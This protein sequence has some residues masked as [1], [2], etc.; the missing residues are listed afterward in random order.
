AEKVQAILRD[1]DMEVAIQDEIS[2][3]VAEPMIAVGEISQGI[4][5]PMHKL[6]IITEKEL[7]KKTQ[8]RV[9]RNQNISNAER[10]KNYQELKI[11][12]YVVH[13]NHGIGK[14]I[15]V[16]TLKVNKLHKDY[17][18][19][20]YSGD[21][22]LYVP[23]DQIDLVQKYVGS[24]GKEPRLYKLGGTE[25]TKVKR[26]VQSSVEDIADELIKLYAER[27]AQK[28]YAFEKDTELQQE[29]EHAFAYQE[30]ADQLQSI[31]EIKKDMEKTRPMDRLLCG[32]VGYG[33]TE[34]A[35]RAI[36]KAVMEGKQAAILVPTTI[37]AQQHFQTMEERF[38]DYPLNIGLLSRFRTKKQ[39][40]ET[41]KGI[42]NGTI[43]IIIGTHR[44]LSND[45]VYKDL[46]LLVVDEEQ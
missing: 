31:E 27:E 36:F 6:A 23:I 39:Q 32:D 16:E 9:R 38:Q 45:I 33:K 26:K 15:G 4:E 34:V 12:D 35:I 22:K 44:L 28:G 5:F 40:T 11:G 25:W 1:Y 10:I 3:P 13:R 14:Y 24:E 42:K 41:I 7:F 17:L 2:L 46:G 30:T 29:F 8:K 18:L 43:D 21:D 19:I 20:Q 37:L